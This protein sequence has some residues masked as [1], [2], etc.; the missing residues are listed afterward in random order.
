VIAGGATRHNEIATKASRS[1]AD[2][3][4]KLDRLRALGYVR[5]RE[6]LGPAES[7]ARATYEL[8]DPFFR[9]WF[10]YVFP[11][12]SRLE[13]GRV[14]E[15]Y[16]EIDR[17]LDTFMGAAFE[18]CCRAWLGGYAGASRVGELDEIGSWMSRDGRTEIDVVGVRRGRYTFLGSCKWRR[19]ADVDVLDDLLSARDG[20]G[21]AGR[22]RL[23]I[24]ARESFSARLRERAADEDVMLVSAADLF[25]A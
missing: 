16:A 15:V 17:D 14:D 24:F 12:R 25:A 19:T 22:A 5:I 2:V 7:A 11:R 23:A 13:R 8:A 9:F 3:S 21:K 10:R 18:E 6:P 20:M 4:D 1:T